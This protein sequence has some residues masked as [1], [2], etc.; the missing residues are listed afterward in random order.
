MTSRCTMLLQ[1]TRLLN[2]GFKR[3]TYA[4]RRQMTGARLQKHSFQYQDTT[5][6]WFSHSCSSHK[7]RHKGVLLAAY[8]R[9]PSSLLCMT[10]CCSFGLTV[11]IR[12]T[13]LF[14]FQ[15]IHA[16]DSI[17][18]TFVQAGPAR[19]VD[20]VALLFLTHRLMTCCASLQRPCGQRERL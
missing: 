6:S 1:R 14:H 11:W 8:Y 17:L 12:F 16:S 3:A 18:Q 15:I 5:P 13:G 10:T 20:L 7:A 19:Q 4:E 2:N 9:D